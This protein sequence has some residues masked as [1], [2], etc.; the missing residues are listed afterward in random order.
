M[1]KVNPWTFLENFLWKVNDFYPMEVEKFRQVRGLLRNY[2]VM[3]FKSF[4]ILKKSF[5]PL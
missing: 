2:L 5:F 3:D 4:E 1:I